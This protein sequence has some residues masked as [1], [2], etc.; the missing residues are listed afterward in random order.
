MGYSTP[1]RSGGWSDRASSQ[2]DRGYRGGRYSSY[3][4]RGGPDDFGR[5]SEDGYGSWREG[6]HM[7][8]PKNSRTERDLFGAPD[9]PDRQHTGINF[10]KYDDIPV[11]ASGNNV[12]EEVLDVCYYYFSF[13]MY[14]KVTMLTKT[15]ILCGFVFI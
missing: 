1:H 5:R 14:Y 11:E 10:E 3:G 4:G 6:V 13:I 2:G 15:I 8:A 12:P 7:I 9:D